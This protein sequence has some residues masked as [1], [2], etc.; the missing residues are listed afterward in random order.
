[1][2][3]LTLAV[4]LAAAPAPDLRTTAEKTGYEHTGRYAEAVALCRAHAEAFPARARCTTFGRTPE[5]R[6]LVALAASADGTLDPTLA[7]A[8]KRHVVLFQGGIHAGEIDG[9]DAGF[10]V[11][12]ELLRSK[13]GGPL[14]GVTAVF[15]PVLNAD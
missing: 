4:A 15:V 13:G 9:K 7:R 12:R 14:A 8:R 10:A 2:L 11:L 3:A 1:M 6:E 5:G